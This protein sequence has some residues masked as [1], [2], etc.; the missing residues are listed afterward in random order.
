LKL[1][2]ISYIHAEGY[3]AA[4]MKH[5]PIAL[6]DSEMPVAAIATDNEMYEK[7]EIRVLTF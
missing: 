3:S 4:E 1:K 6:I 2:E 7:A 5:D